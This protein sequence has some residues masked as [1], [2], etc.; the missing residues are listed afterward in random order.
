MRNARKRR[1]KRENADVALLRNLR[2]RWHSTP[3]TFRL[4]TVTTSLITVGLV[5]AGASMLGILQSHLVGQVDHELISTAQRQVTAISPTLDMRTD[6]EL[7]SNYY[8]RLEYGE[9]HG[10]QQAKG[11]VIITSATRQQFGVPETGELLSFNELDDAHMTQPITVPS[12][13]IGIAWRAVAVPLYRADIPV[14]V[15]TVALPLAGVSQTIYR[16]SLYLLFSSLL[17]AAAGALAA[18]YLVRRSLRPLREIESV[19][20]KIAGGDMTQRVDNEPPTTEVGSLSQSLNKMLTYL[21]ESFTARKASEK[22]MHQ[23][24]SDASHELRTPLAAIRGYGEL[25]RMGGV[26]PEGVPDV[27]GRIESEASRMSELVEDLLKLA[28]LDEGQKLK[29]EDVDLT[30]LVQL[31]ASDLGALDRKR[32]VEIVDLEGNPAREPVFAHVDRNQIMQVLANLVGNAVRYT[33]PGSPVEFAVGTRSS[34]TLLEVRDHGP[35]IAKDER[36]QVFKR[37]YRSDTSRTRN[38]GG[39]GLGLAIVSAIAKAHNGSAELRTTEGGGLTV[40]L[41]LPTVP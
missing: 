17:I 15:A 41:Y 12:S 40:R 39:S 14:G 29:F 2:L 13:K 38:T 24:V 18:F 21:E 31:A 19:A 4:V 7:P 5:L 11:Q 16:T 36:A 1:T 22:K 27:M 35:G 8:V 30:E 37:F 6:P 25:Y 9:R 33:P 34:M 26:P 10:K 32:K 28:R 20:G 3:L 23:F